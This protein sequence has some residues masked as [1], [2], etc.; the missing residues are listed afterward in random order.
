M[1]L[2][3]GRL[4]DIYNVKARITKAYEAKSMGFD[5]MYYRRC[6]NVAP[7]VSRWVFDMKKEH[8]QSQ[9]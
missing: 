2:R 6:G 3:E 8:W 9:T 1:P 7:A 5:V 4:L